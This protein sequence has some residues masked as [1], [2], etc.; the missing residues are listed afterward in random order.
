LGEGVKI[1][2]R[3]KFEKISKAPK[4]TDPKVSEEWRKERPDGKERDFEKTV[5][6][7]CNQ[8]LG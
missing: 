7:W 5:A 6:L 2:S 4:S 3:V 1:P 8:K